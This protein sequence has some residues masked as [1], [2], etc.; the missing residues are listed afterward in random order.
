MKEFAKLQFSG[1]KNS[2]IGA[3]FNVTNPRDSRSG[4]LKAQK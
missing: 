2:D 3:G 4:A 1:K